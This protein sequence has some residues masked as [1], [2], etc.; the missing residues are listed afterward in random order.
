MSDDSDDFDELVGRVASDVA[1]GRHID[2]DAISAL[3]LGPSVRQ[4]LEAMR[5]VE[6]LRQG[7]RPADRSPASTPRESHPTL[8]GPDSSWGSLK[9]V[10]V[11]GAGSFGTVYRA[12]DAALQMQKAVKILHRHVDDAVLREQLT[13]EGRRLAKINH[14]NVVRVHGVDVHD[15]R[16]G[17]SMEFI[18]GETLE[19]EVKARGTCSVAQAAEVGKAVCQALSAV[20]KAGFVHR[21]VKAR[22]IMRERDTGRVVLMDFGAGRGLDDTAAAPSAEL[23][24][25]AIY[26]APEV[27]LHRQDVSEGSDVYSVG[28][29]L[30]Y[31][32]TLSYPIEGDSI[33]QLRAAHKARRRTPLIDR[34]PDLDAAFVKVVEKALAPTRHERYATPGALL[35]A[36]EAGN[37]QR[38]HQWT[39]RLVSVA[40]PVLAVCAALAGL[41]LV[42]T[43]YLNTVLGLRDF[44]S[45]GPWDWFKWGARAN[46]APAVIALGTLWM[47]TLALAGTRLLVGVSSRA[48]RAEQSVAVILR[49]YHLDDVSVLSSLVLVVTTAIVVGTWWYFSPLVGTLF[50]VFP[51]ISTTPTG[52]MALLSPDC[53]D[54]QLAY[55]KG[56][57][58][59]TIACVILWYPVVRLARRRHHLLSRAITISGVAVL[60]FSLILLDL[61]YRLLTHDV[62][63]QEVAWN[64]QSC[65]LFGSRGDQRLVFCPSLFPRT[66]V[67]DASAV[68]ASAS[69]IGADALVLGEAEAKRLK[70]IFRFLRNPQQC[71]SN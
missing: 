38:P 45:E 20:H 25:T 30:Y 33:A 50:S 14:S 47:M 23:A 44:T 71:P 54:Y 46:L 55:R 34:R 59:S 69:P 53:F 35:N 37:V 39:R 31:L 40:V 18:R 24:G 52:K 63:F 42:N 16:A 27:L 21:D 58:A 15:G 7:L 48:R 28:V 12:L 9:L 61:P 8:S 1:A 64:G 49:R 10:E 32:L 2:W 13:E 41:G 56:F 68:T 65:H 70:S 3:S 51:D 62:D 22:N 4:Q 26:M 43:F 19:Q 17:L 67:V 5:L 11:V 66:Y 57:L 6:G 29:L 36:L 60:A